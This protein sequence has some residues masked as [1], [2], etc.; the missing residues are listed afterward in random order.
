MK[1]P[2]LVRKLNDIEY[3]KLYKASAG[4]YIAW[5][6]SGLIVLCVAAYHFLY[7]AW[8]VAV[9]LILYCAGFV[10]CLAIS[11]ALGHRRAQKM[12]QSRDKAGA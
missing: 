12:M 1:D 2:R 7:P 6:F 11:S 10:L 9:L 8:P 4:R 3:D 5:F